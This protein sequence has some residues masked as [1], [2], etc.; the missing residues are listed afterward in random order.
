[1]LS[2]SP[3]SSGRLTGAQSQP[4]GAGAYP[5]TAAARSM[6]SKWWKESQRLPAPPPEEALSFTRRHTRL[7]SDADLSGVGFRPRADSAPTEVLEK[8]MAGGRRDPARGLAATPLAT[9]WEP[10]PLWQHR[11]RISEV[12][13]EPGGASLSA[14]PSPDAGVRRRA[15]T[16]SKGAVTSKLNV[17]AGATLAAK[18]AAADTPAQAA[19]VY[20]ASKTRF[21]AEM[22]LREAARNAAAAAYD[23]DDDDDDDEDDD[24]GG[25]GGGAEGASEDPGADGLSPSLIRRLSQTPSEIA[26]TFSEA[27]RRYAAELGLPIGLPSGDGRAARA[28]AALPRGETTARRGSVHNTSPFNSSAA[29][30]AAFSPSKQRRLNPPVSGVL[31]GFGA[32]VDERLSAEATRSSLARA[33]ARAPAMEWPPP[34]RPSSKLPA[35]EQRSELTWLT[36]FVPSVQPAPWATG[37]HMPASNMAR[38]NDDNDGNDGDHFGHSDALSMVVD[39]IDVD[40]ALC[41]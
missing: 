33:A 23:D 1:V 2:S 29:D 24:W 21:A 19:A 16:N 5:R 11:A 12:E 36:P 10:L 8:L 3:E 22:T 9:V 6:L 28:G 14:S 32:S 34:E 26:A 18:A 25:R 41:A 4:H 7:F 20:V 39:G 15:R 17:S 40:P 37:T 27:K 31:S 38:A 13:E 35:P 30:G